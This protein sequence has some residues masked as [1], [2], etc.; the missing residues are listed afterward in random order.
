[1]QYNRDKQDAATYTFT[2]VTIVFLPIS[3]VASVLGMNTNDVRNID[4]TQWVFWATV[5]PLTVVVIIVSLFATGI[6]K[7]PFRNDK[8]LPLTRDK[9]EL[10]R[11]RKRQTRK[12]NDSRESIKIYNYLV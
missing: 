2:V 3:T 4:K 12:N 5:L 11:K 6:L 9:T 7:W 10:A 8:N 1:M